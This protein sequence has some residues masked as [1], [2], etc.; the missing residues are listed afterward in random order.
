MITSRLK[1]FVWQRHY[2]KCHF[3]A[4]FL[5]WEEISARNDKVLLSSLYKEFLESNKKKNT[6]KISWE[7]QQQIEINKS[8]EIKCKR[9][10]QKRCGASQVIREM[11]IKT[12]MNSIYQIGKHRKDCQHPGLASVEK[13]HSYTWMSICWSIWVES[14]MPDRR[15]GEEVASTLQAGWEPQG[16][17]GLQ[18]NRLV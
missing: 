15:E 1:T 7:S 11:Q 3:F 17:E 4:F 6:Q 10:V 8:Q 2:K 18:P 16:C 14:V 9:P 5:N 12:R 13:R